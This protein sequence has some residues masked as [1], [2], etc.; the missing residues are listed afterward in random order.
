MNS[1]AFRKQRRLRPKIAYAVLGAI[2]IL[3]NLVDALLLGSCGIMLIFGSYA[4]YDN[5]RIHADAAERMY[6]IIE[7][8]REN[9]IS[10]DALVRKNPE[11]SGWLNI[12][13][14]EISHPFA[15][16]DNNSKYASRGIDGT[17]ALSGSLFLD[18]RNQKDF[19][20]FNS[21]IY[22]HHM[23]HDEMFGALDHFLEESF[24]TEHRYG[25]LYADGIL[26]GLEIFAVLKGDAYD[27]VLYAPGTDH[28]HADEY[29][30]YVLEK[31]IYQR[32]IDISADD[33]LVFL[34]TCAD[35]MSNSRLLIIAKISDTVHEEPYI[36]EERIHRILT[37]QDKDSYHIWLMAG[38]AGIAVLIFYFIKHRNKA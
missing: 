31:S 30:E 15:K 32:N 14:T 6:E 19:S 11:V 10:F 25:S 1:K 5:S 27:T 9:C 2:R 20:D 18:Y 26:H 28:E 23:E 37:V 38:I 8:N 21:F 22:G 34:S 4:L 12:Y 7:P 29:L 3:N 13:G 35:G 16:A 17:Y 33:H 36:E 24:F